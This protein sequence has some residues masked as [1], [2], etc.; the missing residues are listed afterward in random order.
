MAL[1][2][3]ML[4]WVSERVREAHAILNSPKSSESQRTVA[5]FVLAQHGGK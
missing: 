1:S 2:I 5:R 4:L 3:T